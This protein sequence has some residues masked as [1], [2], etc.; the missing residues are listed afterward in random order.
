M[1]RADRSLDGLLARLAEKSS[2]ERL[3]AQYTRRYRLPREVVADA[4]QQSF[5]KVLKFHA[6][7]SSELQTLE[8]AERFL[9]TVIRNTLIDD[10]RRSGVIR[11]VEL[12][13]DFV[14]APG[15]SGH[16]APVRTVAG[17]EEEASGQGQPEPQPSVEEDDEATGGGGRNVKRA[18]PPGLEDEML[19][20]L[21]S[22]IL[23]KEILLQLDP[24]YRH[25]VVLLLAEWTPDEMHQKFGQN[26]YRM[27]VWARVKIC[28]IL[29]NLAAVGHE[30][31]ERL[32]GQGGCHRILKS[33]RG[34]AAPTTA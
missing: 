15:S 22:K 6:G 20:A 13:T 2:L 28:R 30:L 8:Q 24:K 19:E 5:Y 7:K 32:H 18:G 4:V 10:I 11:F 29:A 34:N 3:L 16:V 27:R 33:L 25:V 26:G 23:M 17:P 1:G 14:A 9:H 31:A 21:D 12:D